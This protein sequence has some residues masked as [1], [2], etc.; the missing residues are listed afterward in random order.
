MPG[1]RPPLTPPTII[2]TSLGAG[3][4]AGPL[5][6]AATR[7]RDSGHFGLASSECAAASC[8]CPEPQV[9][10]AIS[11]REIAP[12]HGAH[13]GAR[14]PQLQPQRRG[15]HHPG[16]RPLGRRA[17]AR[18]RHWRIHWH[19]HPRLVF[20]RRPAL[21]NSAAVLAGPVYSEQ[22]LFRTDPRRSAPQR[23]LI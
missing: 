7:V 18:G 21:R 4:H 6:E 15:I 14:P 10:S 8:S 11:S 13:A 9:P 19:M 17:Q 16:P 22:A 20:Q 5:H 23:I 12:W 3:C 1:R 2:A